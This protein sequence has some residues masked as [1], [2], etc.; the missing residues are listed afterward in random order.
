VKLS[1]IA[2]DWIA[3]NLYWTAEDRG[4]IITSR[5]D[6][7]YPNVIVRGLVRPRSVTVNPLEGFVTTI[8]RYCHQQQQQRQH[9]LDGV[10]MLLAL[11]LKSPQCGSLSRQMAPLCTV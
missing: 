7:R 11:P 8:A 9:Q 1:G 5:L 2:V 6:G 4:Y 3:D 10:A